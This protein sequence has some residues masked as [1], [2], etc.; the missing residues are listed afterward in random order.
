[1]FNIE[2]KFNASSIDETPQFVSPMKP[3]QYMSK[4]YEEYFYDKYLILLS[5]VSGIDFPS[6]EE[7]LRQVHST[8]PSCMKKYQDFIL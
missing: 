1:M 5:L 2:L 7:Y 6:K 4:S 8:N 3:S